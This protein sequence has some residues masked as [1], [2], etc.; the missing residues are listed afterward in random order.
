[1]ST[2]L[3]VAVPAPAQ[4]RMDELMLAMDI[5]DTLRHEQSLVAREL[6][7]GE[8]D[9]AFVARV[10]QIYASQGIEVSDALIR[11]GVE[12]LKQ[13]RFTYIPPPRTF[14]VRLA[15]LWIDRWRWTRRATIA[16]FVAAFGYAVVA[17]PN[18][19]VAAREYGNYTDAVTDLQQRGQRL[20]KQVD[21]LAIFANSWQANAPAPVAGH[22]G[23]L[24]REYPLQRAA[25]APVVASTQAL[26]AVDDDAFAAA[27]EANYATLSVT[28]DGL[29]LA[30]RDVRA[31]EDRMKAGERLR[32]VAQRFVLAEA[33]L[34]TMTLSGPATATL[35]D[36]RAR[37][38]AA[39][40]AADDAS[41]A[42]AVTTL[43][44]FAASLDLSYSLR[45]VSRQ[46]VQS[47][48]WRYAESAPDG[49]N[50][51]I[52]VEAIDTAGNVVMVPVLNEETQK[53]QNVSRF[54]VRVPY[55]EYERV[56]ADKQD[57]GLIDDAVVGEKRRGELEVNYQI[58][59]AGG[60]ITD[61]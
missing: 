21:A 13:D 59:V 15:E 26:A 18:A 12:A 27:P 17:I 51:Y 23:Q 19:W 35:S 38:E 37:A 39:L 5:V 31:L 16:G 24:A 49:K 41:A 57:N 4:P 1:M 22:L 7:S 54:A 42:T 20:G 2:P 29:E 28:R 14:A 48:V 40:V 44:Q 56:K 43:E 9:E 52:V 60:A 10:R 11:Q 53:T 32:A 58:A 30:E 25:F 33:R 46:G 3:P 50:Y 47:G 45:I 55:A 36:A 8:R 61:W 34:Q 6:A